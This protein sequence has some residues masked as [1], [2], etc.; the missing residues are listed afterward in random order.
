MIRPIRPS[1]RGGGGKIKRDLR[2]GVVRNWEI[3]VE[4]EGS[5]LP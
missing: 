1:D 3:A 2:R 5:D 4:R